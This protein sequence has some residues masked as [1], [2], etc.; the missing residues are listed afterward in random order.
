MNLKN[1]L[2]KKL[3]GVNEE[4]PPKSGQSGFICVRPAQS[5][6]FMYLLIHCFFISL[7]HQLLIMRGTSRRLQNPFRRIWFLCRYIW[8]YIIKI[9]Y[10][11]NCFLP[12]IYPF[13]NKNCHLNQIP[14]QFWESLGRHMTF[15]RFIRY[16]IGFLLRQ[17]IENIIGRKYSFPPQVLR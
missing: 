8:K 13:R 6:Y 10:I 1:K 4:L 3:L 12:Y 2:L 14:P 16:L 9:K 15:P 11:I 5:N 17:F 7:F